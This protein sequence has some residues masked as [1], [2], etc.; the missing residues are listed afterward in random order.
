MCVLC[1]VVLKR[2]LEVIL[3]EKPVEEELSRLLSN[4][5]FGLGNQKHGVVSTL[6]MGIADISPC[7]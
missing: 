4:P 2:N 7:D 1:L 6:K 5:I 3:S